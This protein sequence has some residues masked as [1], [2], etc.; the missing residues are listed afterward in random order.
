M[1]ARQVAI[2]GV[3][4]FFFC[5]SPAFA[6]DFQISATTLAQ[7]Y[8]LGAAD[9]SVVARRRL[10]QYVRLNGYNLLEDNTLFF[11]SSFRLDADFG[12]TNTDSAITGQQY[13]RQAI[14]E[15]DSPNF[16]LLYAYLAGRNLYGRIDFDAGRQFIVDLVDF[17]HF[18]GVRVAVN[19]PWRF[20]VEA[21]AGYEVRA[22]AAL[23]ISSFDLPGVAETADSAPTFGAALYLR[24]LQWGAYSLTGRLSYRKTQGSRNLDSCA[25]D[26][27]TRFECDR[28]TVADPLDRTE[29]QR[30]FARDLVLDERISA[31]LQA[32]LD[33][34]HVWGAFSYNLVQGWFDDLLLG[35]QGRLLSGRLIL[36]SEYL[37]TRPR[38]DAD[39]IFNIFG[40][41]ALDDLRFK[42]GW[43]FQ[44]GYEIYGRGFVRFFYTGIFGTSPADPTVTATGVVVGGRI[45]HGRR[46][47]TTVDVIA[48]N[49]YGGYLFGGDAWTRFAL[50]DNKLEL[51]GRFLVLRFDDDRLENV[52]GI[53]V[54]LQGGARWVLHRYVA[55]HLILE[56]STNRLYSSIFRVY[57][58]LDLNFW[59]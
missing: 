15:L 50:M 42:V 7:G 9:G 54:T 48:Q 13:L 16:S 35:V 31:N 8:E 55:V 6:A 26:P 46:A 33:K 41:Q 1:K 18:D 3:F 53:N 2:P 25:V 59:L 45:P 30:A 17:F 19:T 34:V 32:R 37:R 12:L 58:L 28:L 38:F 14:R 52:N 21:F 29:V 10:S 44:N 23:G 22:G 47:Y 49:G 39:S 51:D 57:G 27:T 5:A 24:D 36:E 11:V 40:T 56:E 43:D 20:G 4:L